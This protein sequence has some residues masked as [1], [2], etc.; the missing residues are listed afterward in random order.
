[1]GEI[2]FIDLPEPFE[3]ATLEN[4]HTVTAGSI[5]RRIYRF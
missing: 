4:E 5:L 1:M 2:H 3:I